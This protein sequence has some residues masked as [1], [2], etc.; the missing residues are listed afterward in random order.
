[1]RLR[2]R[3]APRAGGFQ[4]TGGGDGEEGGEKVTPD[5]ATCWTLIH[6]AAGGDHSAR[7]EF[8]RLYEPIA[9]AYFVARWWQAPHVTEIDDAVQ[10]AFVECFKANGVLTRAVDNEPGG[11][12]AYFHGVLR[13]LARR[14][15]STPAEV[16][17]LPEDHAAE[18]TSLSVAFDK[19]WA[20]SL[21]KEAARIQAQMA[22]ASGERAVRRVELLRLRFQ[23]G[24]PIRK[25]AEVWEE[26]PANLHHEY[27]TAR[28]EFQMALRRVMAFHQP[29][30][31]GP[32][33]EMACR[34]LLGFLA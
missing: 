19:A 20:R 6:A 31:T 12:R 18:D 5:D 28:E 15:E 29:K 24:L 16:Q 8:A 23:E 33:L 30:A 7:D 4:E 21:L 14:H 27:A 10:I 32:E 25:I 11:F 1:M 2:L 17:P 26:D 3:L 22:A 13:N 34:D 9:R